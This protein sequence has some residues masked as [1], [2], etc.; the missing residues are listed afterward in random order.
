MT[1][2]KQPPLPSE[3]MSCPLVRD[4][5]RSQ[6]CEVIPSTVEA[7]NIVEEKVMTAVGNLPCAPEDLAGVALS[8]REALANGPCCTVTGMSR[9]SGCWSRAFAIARPIRAC[10]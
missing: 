6:F 8:L 7:L 5:L 3:E 1:N 4:H 10:C 9:P 2:P